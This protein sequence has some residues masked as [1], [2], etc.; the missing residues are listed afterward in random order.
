MIACGRG[1]RIDVLDG[2]ISA[3]AWL[4]YTAMTQFLG[5]MGFGD[6]YKVMG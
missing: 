2:S 1:N 4:F 6:A 5:F 3:L